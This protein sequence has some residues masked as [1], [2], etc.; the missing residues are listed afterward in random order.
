MFPKLSPDKMQAAMKKM[1]IKT[2]QVPATE[3]VIKTE[4]GEI[5][6]RNPQVMQVDMQ[7]QKTF[8]IMG[9]V[10]EGAGAP[11]E[12]FSADDVKMVAEQARVSDDEAR[13]ALEEANGDIA[14]AI[15]KL[16]K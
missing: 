3:V 4:S 15:L 7:G 2:E 10:E 11:P 12:K 5:K 8:Q 6:I 14:E 9:D 13:K 16:Q 1:G